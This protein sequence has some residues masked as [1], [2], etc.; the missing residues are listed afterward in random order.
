VDGDGHDAEPGGSRHE[1][2]HGKQQTA[3]E[4][5]PATPAPPAGRVRVPGRRPGAASVTGFILVVEVVKVVELIRLSEIIGFTETGPLVMFLRHQHLTS[6]R[7][8][9]SA[10]RLHG[11]YV[12]KPAIT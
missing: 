7:H 5:L 10:G 4:A 12:T 9:L 2:G 3:P 1:R 11:G 8:S 6:A